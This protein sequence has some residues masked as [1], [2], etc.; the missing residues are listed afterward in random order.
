MGFIEFEIGQ[1]SIYH[2]FK[3]WTGLF[4]QEPDPV[5]PKPKK[6]VKNQSKLGTGLLFGSLIIPVFKTMQ[7]ITCII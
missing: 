2:C 7:F 1:L 5:Q 6:P 3:N 4:N